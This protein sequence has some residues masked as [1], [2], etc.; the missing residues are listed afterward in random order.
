MNNKKPIVIKKTAR[1]I[2]EEFVMNLK[3]YFA[4][5]LTLILIIGMLFGF[6]VLY[7]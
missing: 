5:S 4:V 2:S 3:K 6:V 1:E 7:W